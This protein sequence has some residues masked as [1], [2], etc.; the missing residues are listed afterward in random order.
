[1]SELR[2]EAKLETGEQAEVALDAVLPLLVRRLIPGEAEDL[3][4]QLPSL[5]RERLPLPDGPDKR[6]TRESI[7]AELVRRLEVAPER[8]AEILRAVG[9]TLARSVSPGQIEE[10]RAQL[11]EELR[12]IFPA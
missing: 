6:V 5:L 11:P 2:A 8:A 1:M 7:E 4:A 9:A 12:A 10:V 3:A